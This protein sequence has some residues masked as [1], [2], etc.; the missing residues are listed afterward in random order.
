MITLAQYLS[1]AQVVCTV[2]SLAPSTSTIYISNNN[3]NFKVVGEFIIKERINIIS[4]TPKFGIAT[5]GAVFEILQ[6]HAVQ[7]PQLQCLFEMENQHYDS[8]LNQS[9]ISSGEL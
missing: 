7:S 5:G 1:D 4:V 3:L 6:I 9:T 2:P 8:D